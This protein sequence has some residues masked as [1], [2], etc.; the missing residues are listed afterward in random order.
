MEIADYIA[1]LQREG[2]LLAS[3]AESAAL[4]NAVPTCPGW[5]LRDLVRHVGG[6]HRWATAHVSKARS[7]NFDPF[8]EMADHWPPDDHLI[9]WFR[10]GHSALLAALE[11]APDDLECFTF[12]PAPSPKAFWARRQAHETGMH[13]ADADA[14]ALGDIRPFV[15]DQAIDGIEELL[16]GFMARPRQKLRSEQ[17]RTIALQAPE[18]AWL[19]R[20]SPDEPVVSREAVA[21]ADCHVRASASDLFL[22]VWN[23]R[24]PEE[25]SVEGDRSLLSLWRETVF[26][27]W[28]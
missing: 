26:V 28:R 16:F 14:A 6:L 23:R 18:R 1:I 4:D 3:V 5:T 24:T 7:G 15:T 12:L 10:Q 11:S 20:L 22:L 17:P 25:L 27:R 8:V 21:A 13:R 19:V 2:L 9:D